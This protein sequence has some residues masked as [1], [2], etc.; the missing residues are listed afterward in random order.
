MRKKSDICGGRLHRVHAEEDSDTVR[1][2]LIIL[3]LLLGDR[4]VMSEAQ[5]LF[6]HIPLPPPMRQN[7]AAII[8]AM[9]FEERWSEMD[10]QEREWRTFLKRLFDDA[11]YSLAH[12]TIVTVSFSQDQ[13]NQKLWTVERMIC[14][15]YRGYA[16]GPTSTYKKPGFMSFGFERQEDLDVARNALGL[17]E[18]LQA[19]SRLFIGPQPGP[20]R[21]SGVNYHRTED[22]AASS[23]A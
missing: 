22:S 4:T 14:G 11:H 10:Q 13:E 17:P 7:V 16:T 9:S 3:L 18:E 15:M 6:E 1:N 2:Y 20:V 8:A 5:A 12:P 21:S 23:E 19:G